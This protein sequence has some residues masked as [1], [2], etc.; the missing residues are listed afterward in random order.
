MKAMPSARGATPY[1]ILLLVQCAIFGFAFV[2]IK[3]L[4]NDGFSPLFLM[5]VRFS[6]G[7]LSLFFASVVTGRMKGFC[8]SSSGSGGRELRYGAIA[9]AVL[10]FAFTL[11]T[12]GADLTTPA[13]NGLL[14]GTFV[15]FVPLLAMAVRRRFSLRPFLVSILC[16]AG[17]IVVSG[18]STADL[19]WNAGDL[20]SVGCGL[21]FA[22]HFLILGRYASDPTI[23]TLRLTQWQLLLVA[24]FAATG[25]GIWGIGDIANASIPNAVH[26]F[27]ILGVVA[28]AVTYLIQTIVQAKLTPVTVSVVSTSESAFAVAIALITGFQS[29]TL[30]LGLGSIIILTAMVLASGHESLSSKSGQR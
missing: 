13:K 3:G 16:F 5:S 27:I 26:S 10:F 7:F 2:V 19:S 30:T 17:V 25:A 4:L 9:G 11:Q 22:V 14:T 6:V 15:V 29:P 23:D 20:L 8:L 18:A 24:L 1:V 21:L 12:L 28:T